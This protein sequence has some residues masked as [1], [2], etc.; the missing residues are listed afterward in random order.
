MARSDMYRGLNPTGADPREISEV[1]NGILTGKTNNTGD[2]T[3][4]QSATSTVL[5]NALIGYNSVILFTPMNDKGA[6]EMSTVYV[7]TLNKGSAVI[8][9]G[10]HNFDCI[11]KYIVVG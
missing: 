8:A 5:Y 3:T 1:T 4:A 2:F 7:Q 10:S 11:F 9:H 6:F